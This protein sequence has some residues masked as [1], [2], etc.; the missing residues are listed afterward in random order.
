MKT[1]RTP[2]VLAA[3]LAASLS[4]LAEDAPKAKPHHVSR[5]ETL[6]AT[7]TAINPATREITFKGPKGNSVT[8][9][10]TD[11]VKRFNELKVGDQVKVTYTESIAARLARP[12]EAAASASAEAGRSKGPQPGAAAK[13]EVTVV[14]TLENVDPKVPSVTFKTENGEMHT[15]HVLHAKNLEGYKAGDKV[16]LTYTESLAIDVEPAAKK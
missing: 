12:G 6:T 2:I 14:V 10:A 5:T 8:L 11:A 16:A 1:W 3:F 4:V 7:I 15:V 9:V 13:S